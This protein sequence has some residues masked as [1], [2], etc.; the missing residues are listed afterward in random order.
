MILIVQC[1]AFA[2]V[3][4]DCTSGSYAELW[5]IDPSCLSASFKQKFSSLG[6]ESHAGTNKVPLAAGIGWLMTGSACWMFAL[7]HVPPVAYPF[8]PK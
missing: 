2:D 5:S 3:P 1:S 7:F 8:W 4:G 6:A